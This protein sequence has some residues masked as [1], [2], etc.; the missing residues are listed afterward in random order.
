MADF[1]RIMQIESGGNPNARTGSYH[2]LYQLSDSEFNKYGG[3][4]IYNAEDNTRA[5]HAKF[6]AEQERFRNKYGR[7]PE[8]HELYMTHQQGEGGYGAHTSN[9]TGLAWQ[10]MG[11]TLE[12]RQK[13]A[14]WAREAI[15]G[16][17][18]PSMKARFP[19]GVDTVTSADFM[20][21]W[22]DR[23]EGNPMS[24][25]FAA[26]RRRN[27]NPMQAAM[28]GGD[29]EQI[30]LNAAYAQGQGLQGPP[31]SLGAQFLAGGPGALFGHPGRPLGD[32]MMLAGMALRDDG[33][34]LVPM[35]SLLRNEAEL[36]AGKRAGKWSVQ[37]GPN[38]EMIKYH[39]DGRH[40]ILD[41]AVGR[42]VDPAVLKEQTENLQQ[43]N[44]L[45]APV[46]LL[47]RSTA[48]SST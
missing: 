37:I 48:A 33:K 11:G 25:A 32:S 12:G 10:N 44:I 5:A 4:D 8:T 28:S 46:C 3:G 16:N 30:P 13:G 26:E 40:Q 36:E 29:E 17:M 38:G 41:N 14:G 18:T 22:K 27:M 15:W 2:G 21:L 42:K 20:S 6:A 24:S 7:D 1:N 39:S 31:P 19:G 23:V 45:S 9:P 35:A 47:R 43:S 34:G